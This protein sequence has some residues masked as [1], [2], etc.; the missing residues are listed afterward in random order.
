MFFTLLALI[1]FAPVHASLEAV[2]SKKPLYEFGVFGGSAFLPDYPAADEGRIRTLGAPQIRYRGLRYRS[3]EE[4]SL[5]A[6]IF[7]NPLYGFDLSV[8]GA[9]A[10]NS[11]KNEAR[12]GMKDLDWVGEIGPRFYLFLVRTEKLWI[13]VFFPVRWATSTDL[14]SITYQGIVFAP[15]MSARYYFDNSKF[16]SIILSATRTHT[17]HQMQEFYYQVDEKDATAERP[18]YDAKAG[19]MGSSAS[20]SYIYERGHTGIYTGVSG[21]SY[22][23]AANAGSPLH[24]ADYNYAVYLG[25]SYLFFQSEARGYQ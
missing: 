6:R 18:A 19:Y 23:G 12:T 13:R 5:K 22:K 20:L 16:N 25:F 14:K 24:K 15:A 7:L 3:D 21:A 11:E 9:I 8:S 2:R 17:T 4:D 1:L 10:T